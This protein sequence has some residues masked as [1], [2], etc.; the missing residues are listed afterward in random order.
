MGA[1]LIKNVDIEKEVKSQGGHQNLFKIYNG[2]KQEKSKQKVSVFTLEKKI[3]EMKKVSKQLKEEAINF[4]KKEGQT[5]AKFKHPNLLSLV[6]PLIEDSKS[7]AFATERIIGSLEYFISKNDIIN[8]F[9]SNLEVK[10]HL[11]EVLEGLNFLHNDVKIAHG[12]ISPEN[13]YQTNDYRWKIGGF[14]FGTQLIQQSNEKTVNFSS[15]NSFPHSFPLKFNPNVNFISPEIAKNG[16]SYFTS[17]VFSFG[18]LI[19]TLFKIK[20]EKNCDRPYFFNVQDIIHYRDKVEDFNFQEL[21]S[22]EKALQE[23]PNDF[24]RILTRMLDKNPDSRPSVIK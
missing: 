16:V 15:I 20:Y 3:F 21:V 5:L 6:E 1:Q 22:N 24:K 11:I 4:I 8:L 14:I 7:M 19:I 9:P 13:I 18:L 12:A 17:D 10:M 2:T 23:I